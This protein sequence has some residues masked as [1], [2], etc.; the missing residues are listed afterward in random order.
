MNLTPGEKFDLI[1]T[2]YEAE[3]KEEAK[4]TS[5]LQIRSVEFTL[6][7]VTVRRARRRKKMMKIK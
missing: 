2:R 1:F 4:Q 7:L 6:S 5:H 3:S